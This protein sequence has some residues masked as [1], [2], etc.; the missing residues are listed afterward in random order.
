MFS[1]RPGTYPV[2]S[3]GGYQRPNG[4][5][6]G[7]CKGEPICKLFKPGVPGSKF[8]KGEVEPVLPTAQVS[9]VR[10]RERRR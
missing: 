4:A 10:G 2:E 5:R 3:E 7:L 8:V 6:A 9:H 1:S